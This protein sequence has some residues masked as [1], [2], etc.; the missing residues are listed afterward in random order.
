VSLPFASISSSTTD[1]AYLSVVATAIPVIL[2]GY[3]LT[4]HQ[5]LG[6]L[7]ARLGRQVKRG[8]I[9]SKVSTEEKTL[10]KSATDAR[11]PS[12]LSLLLL[13]ILL[14]IGIVLPSAAEF[15]ALRALE[16][17]H[18]SSCGRSVTFAGTV[19]AGLVLVLPLLGETI[20]VVVKGYRTAETATPESRPSGPSAES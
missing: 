4:L 1:V 14:V 5:N 18:L 3:I 11:I 15:I 20:R 9:F 10:P 2:I 17:D 12:A 16:T 13:A 8:R 19:A 6:K 7:A